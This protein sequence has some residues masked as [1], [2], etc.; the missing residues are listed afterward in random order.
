MAPMDRDA[1]EEVV[2]Q[3][4]AARESCRAGSRVDPGDEV[5]REFID[6]ARSK[7]VSEHLRDLTGHRDRAGHRECRRHLHR[8]PDAPLGE[9]LVK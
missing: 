8:V 1:D 3:R 9:V 2:A 4:L 7:A 6:V 5:L